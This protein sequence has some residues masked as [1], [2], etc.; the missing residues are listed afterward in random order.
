LFAIRVDA[1]RLAIGRDE[2]IRELQ[3]RGVAC[4]VHWRPLH[5]HRYYLET[6]AWDSGC[7]P[8]ATREWRRLISLPIYP[9]MTA[10]ER[11]H[12][13]ESVKAVCARFAKAA[14]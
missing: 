13:A 1:D 2:F 4:S 7:L 10:A 14:R 8:A 5:L 3:S 12:V 9:S 6:F 11:N